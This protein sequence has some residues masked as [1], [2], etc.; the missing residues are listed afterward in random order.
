MSK[1]AATVSNQ[2]EKRSELES[3]E[4]NEEIDPDLYKEKQKIT[5]SGSTFSETGHVEDEE[6]AKDNNS[7]SLT[8]TPTS[9]SKENKVPNSQN[10][11]SSRV[12]SGRH[13]MESAINREKPSE[14]VPSKGSATAIKTPLAPLVPLS[15]ITK[16]DIPFLGQ[17]LAVNIAKQP[18]SPAATI[19]EPP[20]CKP[21][22]L[23]TS[24][25]GALPPLPAAPVARRSLNNNISGPGNASSGQSEIKQQKAT[26]GAETSLELVS[27]KI[28][29][30]KSESNIEMTQANTDIENERKKCHEVTVII[31]KITSASVAPKNLSSLQSD[32]KASGSSTNSA[33]PTSSNN[34]NGGE[35]EWYWDYEENCWKEC[36]PD[37]DYEWEYIESDDENNDGNKNKHQQTTTNATAT[38]TFETDTTATLNKRSGSLQSLKEETISS[39]GNNNSRKVTPETRGSGSGQQPAG[40]L[41]KNSL[42]VDWPNKACKYDK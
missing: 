19:P 39:S 6:A 40:F 31:P 17:L 13:L 14:V 23:P 28:S 35:K 11:G 26:L 30:T 33:K 41:D 24:V 21:P 37:E 5:A 16:Y 34:N 8:T 18:V 12:S 38:A 36:D 15:S 1:P 3:L 9:S 25:G 22:S 4:R 27:A 32:T 2:I 7:S 10:G 42:A 20:K 29:S